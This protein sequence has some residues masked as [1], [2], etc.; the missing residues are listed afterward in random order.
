MNKQKWL[1][2]AAENGFEN[3]EIYQSLSRERTI[4]WYEGKMDTFVTSRVLGTALR[5]KTD[6]KMAIMATEDANDANMEKIISAMKAQ[7]AAITSDDAGEILAPEKNEEVRTERCWKRP[8]QEEIETLL[9]KTEQAILAFDSRII[10]V[11]DLEWS[12]ETVQTEITNSRGME[13][14][15]ERTMQVLVA[16]AAAQD[17]TEVKNDYSFEPVEDINVFDADAFVKE[18]CEG[19]LEKL[20]ASPIPSG[21]Y[22]VILEKKAMTALF[23]AFS[24]MFSGDL[25]GKGI[26]PLKN[27]LDKEV[28][29]SC[30]T[31]IDDPQNPKAP[32]VYNYDD[33]GH[34]AYRKTVVEN[35]VFRTILHSTKSASRMNAESTGS[36]FKGSYSDAVSARPC[37]MSIEPG[38]K[39]L[40][41][42]YAEMNDGLVIT[43]F[44]GL[45][46]GIDTVTTDFSLQCSGYLVKDGKKDRSVTL[47]TAA[48]NFLDLMKHVRCI[49]SDR[50]WKLRSITCPS[51]LFEGIAVSGE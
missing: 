17:G 40:E 44:Q 7:A 16:G 12:E 8:S 4:S 47:I 27:S 1:S 35:G 18:L 49:G 23:T 9:K 26:S 36:G 50:E 24:G 15:N 31:V 21:T 46:A 45:H 42:L 20:G 29:S 22:P 51:I 34:P 11:T 5:G 28:F 32:A 6:G 10:Q 33:E 48:G 30:V 41:E 3:F 13:V 39:S 14:R 19:V 37:N 25:I 43:T 2:Y 38:E